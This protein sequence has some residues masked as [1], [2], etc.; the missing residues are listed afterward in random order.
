[1]RA[2]IIPL[3]LS[4]FTMSIVRAEDPAPGKQ[5][6]QELKTTEGKSV[7]YLLYLPKAYDSK[8]K[9]PLLLFLHGRGESDGP[10]S[11]VKKWGPPRL[12]DRGENP[13][14]SS[15]RRSVRP[16]PSPGRSPLSRNYFWPFWTILATPAKSIRIASI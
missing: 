2:I 11:I 4:A 14:M 12:I 6:E 9:W 10:L 3:V 7:R 5:V 15:C 1:M 8:Q 16:I 13:P